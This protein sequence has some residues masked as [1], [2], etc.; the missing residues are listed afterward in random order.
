MKKILI[1]D[2]D[3]TIIDSNFV[4]KSVIIN[5]IKEKYNVE[6]LNKI[7]NYNFQKCTRYDLISIAKNKPI[8]HHEKLEIDCKIN[9]NVIGAHLDQNLFE[10]FKFCSKNKIKI[11]LVSNTPHESLKYIVNEL[12]IYDFFYEVIGKKLNQE[13]EEIFSKII[14]NESI[15][16]SK[17]LSVGDN[18]NDYLA[19]KNNK[20][21]F[22]GIYDYSLLILRNKIPITSTLRG[23][24]DS[25]K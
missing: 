9:E 2:F 18:F 4:K 22:H 10:L 16:P 13:K 6:I 21:P 11:I 12:K 20:I 1:L 8:L 23:V 25:L 3:G 24:I 17:I 7:D 14:K 5:H 19:S 15:N